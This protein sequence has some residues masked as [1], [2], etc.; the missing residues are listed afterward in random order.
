[1]K[2]NR[3]Q[4]QTLALCMFVIAP[5]VAQVASH[6]PTSVNTT[7]AANAAPAAAA[8]SASLSPVKPVMDKP[9]VRINGVELTDRDLLR[10]MLTIFPYARQHNGFPKAEEEKIRMGA[11][12]MIE[13]EELVYQEAVRRGMAIAPARL[14]KAQSDFRAQFPN[15]EAYNDY[16]KSEMQG[17][18][19]ELRKQIRRSLLI[20][21]LLKQEVNDKSKVSLI[22]ARAYY[23]KNPN[24]FHYG[25]K[26]AIQTI[27]IMP[28]AKATDADKKDAKKRAD[29]AWQKAKATK[30]YEEFGLL[31]EKVSEDDFH[32]NM[33]D[34]HPVDRDKLPPEVIKAVE[35][36]QPGQVSELMTFDGFYTFFRLNQRIPAGKFPFDQ[37][38]DKLRE[39]LQKHKYEQLRAGLDKKLRQNANVQEL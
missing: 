7:V 27:S 26:F 24:A 1:M 19:Q 21:E 38:K 8:P 36:M 13:F 20:E 2:I 39:D 15:D 16:L 33:G 3:F 25:E 18:K 22:Q 10:E 32:V 5:A 6:A 23:D 31:A 37:V 17:S 11:L 34:H 28:S 29:D 9:V 30:T 12:K 35:A 4:L 14:Q